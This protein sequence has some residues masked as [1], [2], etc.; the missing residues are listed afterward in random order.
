MAELGMTRLD[1][2]TLSPDGAGGSRP[3]FALAAVELLVITYLSSQLPRLIDEAE[4]PLFGA[5]P[6]LLLIVPAAFALAAAAYWR[7]SLFFARGHQVAGASA[8][9][10]TSLAVES[11]QWRM[12]YA[13]SLAGLRRVVKLAGVFLLA[14]VIVYAIA[15]WGWLD[16]LYARTN[17]AI[18][19][20]ASSTLE[21]I[22]IVLAFS[23]PMVIL[24]F[25]IVVF[26]MAFAVLVPP[27]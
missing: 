13:M 11:A 9:S 3:V 20:L 22:A 4:V 5:L 16:T 1:R 2:N 17:W 24:I 27:R 12:L 23:G 18:L 21:F 25:T 8:E 6:R 14:F 7:H 19:S 15:G 10:R 26:K